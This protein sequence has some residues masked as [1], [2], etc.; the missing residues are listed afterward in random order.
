MNTKFNREKD[1]VPF[2]NP[3]IVKIFNDDVSIEIFVF[4]FVIREEKQ[5]LF[6]N[7]SSPILRINKE[8]WDIKLINN[9]IIKKDEFMQMA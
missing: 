8:I 4:I 1:K 5:I 2:I 9:S 3:S 6:W 7:K